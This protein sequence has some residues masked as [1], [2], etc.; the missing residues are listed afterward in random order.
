MV[1][2]AVVSV[3]VVVHGWDVGAGDGGSGGISV[4]SVVSVTSIS[5]PFGFGGDFGGLDLGEGEEGKSEFHCE[6]VS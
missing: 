3:T 5:G 2:V 1:R 6:V 4:V